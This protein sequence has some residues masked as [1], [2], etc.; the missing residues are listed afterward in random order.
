MRKSPRPA[1]LFMLLVVLTA[2]RPGRAEEKPDDKHRSPRATVRA[3]LTAVLIAQEH[4]EVI[5]NAAACLDL[6]GRPADQRDSGGLLARQLEAGAAPGWRSR[7]AD[8]SSRADGIGA[9]PCIAA[10]DEG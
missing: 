6:S 9:R 5:Q 8:S 7:G 2:A 10:N 4:P 3:L 1:V